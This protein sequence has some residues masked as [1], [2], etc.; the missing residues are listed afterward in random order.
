MSQLLKAIVDTTGRMLRDSVSTL[1]EVSHELFEL[2]VFFEAYPVEKR[3][4]W[5]CILN[6]KSVPDDLP[7]SH[8]DYNT[9]EA[10]FA[11]CIKAFL[12][13]TIPPVELAKVWTSRYCEVYIASEDF[14]YHWRRKD[15]EGRYWV[16][17]DAYKAAAPY[18]AIMAEAASKV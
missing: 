2:Y 1:C 17:D 3:A 18:V 7:L 4:E 5:W 8:V 6:N 11:D 16:T 15:E 14:D 13:I 12:A 9:T 10:V